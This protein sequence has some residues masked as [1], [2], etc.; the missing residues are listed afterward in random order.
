MNESIIHSEKKRKFRVDCDMLLER[1]V[2]GNC[3]MKD[4]DSQKEIEGVG[5]VC[6]ESNSGYEVQDK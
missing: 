4:L 5:G 1:C 2:M 3:I 6:G